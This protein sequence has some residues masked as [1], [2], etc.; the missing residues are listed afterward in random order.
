MTADAVHASAAPGRFVTAVMLVHVLVLAVIAVMPSA[1]H[2]QSATTGVIEGTA[3]G[4]EGIN[5]MVNLSARSNA[6]RTCTGTSNTSQGGFFELL[7]CGPGVYT[8]N[9]SSPFNEKGYRPQ[10]IFGV[11][12]EGGKRTKLEVRMKQGDALEEVGTPTM[13]TQPILDVAAELSKLQAQINEL[14]KQLDASRKQP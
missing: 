6:G 13:T 8:V 10:R 14:R 7:D 4:T 2:G 9:V 3:T 1:A 5:L 11:I 12:V